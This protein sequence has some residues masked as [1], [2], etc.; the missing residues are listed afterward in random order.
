MADPRYYKP[1]FSL[2]VSLDKGVSFEVRIPGPDDLFIIVQHGGETWDGSVAGYGSQQLRELAFLI[3]EALPRLEAHEAAR[4][5][6]YSRPDYAP[7]LPDGDPPT[8]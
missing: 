5:S 4:E 7:P 3:S 8:E 1:V 6:G 2:S